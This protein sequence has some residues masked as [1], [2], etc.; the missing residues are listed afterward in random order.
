MLRFQRFSTQTF[1]LFPCLLL[2]AVAFFYAP[3]SRSA[4]VEKNKDRIGKSDAP[5]GGTFFQ[6]LDAEP[7][8][9]NPLTSTDAYASAIQGYVVE[10]LMNTNI[11]TYKLE[12]ELA[13]SYEEDPQGMWYVFHLR[14]NVLWHDGQPL[15]AEDVKFSFDAVADPQSKF[16][17]AHLRP[18]FENIE[19]AEVINPYTIKFIVKEKYFYNLNVLANRGFLS[20]LPKHIYGD[21]NKKNTRTLIGTGPYRLDQ[22]DKGKEIILT[23]NTQWW[24][25][26]EP[27]YAGLHKFDRIQFRFVKE[28]SS[29]LARMEKGEIDYMGLTPEAYVQKTNHSPWGKTVFKKQVENQSSRP[30]G[31]V[32]WNFNNPIFSDKDVRVALAQLMDRKLMIDKFRFGMSLPATGPW[33]QQSPY[34]DPKVK[35][36][37]YDLKGAVDLLKKKGWADSNK[38][39]VL[40]KK[41]GDQVVPFRFTLLMASKD[42]EKY[43]TIYK[44][45][46]K[47][48]GIDME[49]K[50]VEWNSFMKALDE[51]KF[52]ALS[53]GWSAGSLDLDPKQIWHSSSTRPGGS[54]FINYKNTEVD[55]LIDKGRKELNK[56]KRI[57]Y[58]RQV[59]A[60]IAA[61]AP[62]AFLFNDK[63]IRYA[64]SARMQME[65]PTYNYEIGTETWWLKKD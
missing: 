6:V 55:E 4:Q 43:M 60:K 16:D 14:Q 47:K 41:I 21:V 34:A 36:I 62:Y 38:D 15:T 52:D 23:R 61:D 58:F 25:A 24:G 45:S 22:Y 17:T 48:A 29:Q 10:G 2:I 11:D 59:Y 5:Q 42:A 40:E 57:G 56:Q 1:L 18:Y 53:L 27:Q 32:A 63:S 8:K 46:L 3:C 7:E 19:K 54:N 39:G 65:K 13:E 12:P 51:R 64:Y 30:Y 49:I 31:F 20:V 28:E 33:Y 9:L 50:I 26:K 37:M 35:P 44:E